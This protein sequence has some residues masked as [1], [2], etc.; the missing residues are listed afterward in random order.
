MVRVHSERTGNC[1]KCLLK[2]SKKGSKGEEGIFVT[3]A[4]QL[5]ISDVRILKLRNLLN[6]EHPTS[7]KSITLFCVDDRF[8]L[9]FLSFVPI[10]SSSSNRCPLLLLLCPSSSSSTTL[11]GPIN[12]LVYHHS[13]K[14]RRRGGGGSA[15]VAGC[16]GFTHAWL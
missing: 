11:L 14:R 2:T 3:F 8:L 5:R 6:F 16:F 4:F 15:I 9:R 7:K 10:F 1:T 12:N 13:R